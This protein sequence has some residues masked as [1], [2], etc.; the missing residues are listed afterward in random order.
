MHIKDFQGWHEVKQEIDKASHLPTF[1]EREIWWCSVGVNVGH[2]I[3]GKSRFYN[4]PV[5]IVKKFN[6]RLF[7]GVALSTQIKQDKHY[8][9]IDF[10]GKKQSVMLSHLRL[11]DTKRLHSERMGKLPHKQF[12][13]V[14]AALRELLKEKP[15]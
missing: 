8:F 6:A 13:A 4:R 2:E 15:L 14:K 1:N 3:D 7:W 11:Y 5:L 10:H 9:L 12:E